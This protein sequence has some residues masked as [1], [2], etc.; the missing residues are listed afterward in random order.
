MV[1]DDKGL[2]RSIPYPLQSAPDIS[3]T[4]ARS[5]YEETPMGEYRDDHGSQDIVALMKA[6]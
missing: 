3:L 1:H 6:K 2:I 5:R 4:L